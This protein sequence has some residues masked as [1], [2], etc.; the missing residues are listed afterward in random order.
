MK[1]TTALILVGGF[2]FVGRNILE[3]IAQ[4]PDFAGLAPAVIDDLSNAASGYDT[5]DLPFYEGGYETPQ[6]LEFLN[7]LD[8]QTAPAGRIF[9]F[10]AGE[11]RVAE[12]KDRPLDFIEAN[13]AQPAQFVMEAI[14]PGDHFILISTAGALFDG[15]FEVRTSSAYCP[16]NFYGAT[17]AAEEMVLELSLIHI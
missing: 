12:S 6:A 8:T 16:K 17:K 1:N 3:V 15:T 9:V 10:L 14:R 11:T 2:G 5:L 4:D 7:Y 13:I